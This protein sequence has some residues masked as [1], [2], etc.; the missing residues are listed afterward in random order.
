MSD[1]NRRQE[2]AEVQVAEQVV[3]NATVA[4]TTVEAVEAVEAEETNVTVAVTDGNQYIGLDYAATIKAMI[5]NGGKRYKDVVV[6]NVN[7]T[8]KDNYT[9]V[10][11]TT[12]SALPA[13]VAEDDDYVLGV[14]NIVYSSLYAIV[15]AMRENEDLAWMGNV[16]LQSPNAVQL[17][18]SGATLDIVQIEYAAGEVIYNPFTTKDEDEGVEYDHDCIINYIVGI[19]LSKIGEKFADKLADKMLG[20]F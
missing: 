4:N 3:N 17:V 7:T 1:T 15:G 9:M 12:K 11:F 18:L 13:Y 14:S 8:D 2:S 10:S 20:E 5:A 19:K 6:K 16:L